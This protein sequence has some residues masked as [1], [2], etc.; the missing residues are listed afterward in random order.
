MECFATFTGNDLFESFL[1]PWLTYSCGY[2]ANADNLN[3]AQVQ[4]MELIAKKL[5]LK[6]GMRVLDIGQSCII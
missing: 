5:Q 6:P 2:W 4:K 3:D 1:D